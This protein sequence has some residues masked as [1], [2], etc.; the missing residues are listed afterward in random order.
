MKMKH[1]RAVL[2][3]VLYVLLAGSISAQTIP[4]S[5]VIPDGDYRAIKSRLL[6]EDSGWWSN[7]TEKEKGRRRSFHF[8]LPYIFLPS[9]VASGYGIPPSKNYKATLAFVRCT[10]SASMEDTLHITYDGVPFKP[11]DPL[12]NG[13]VNSYVAGQW[14]SHTIGINLSDMPFK[15]RLG[16]G[17]VVRNGEFNVEVQTN[18]L[19]QG[20]P[21][22]DKKSAY[23][24]MVLQLQ[25]GRVVYLMPGF[26]AERKY[27]EPLAE[28]MRQDGIVVD[29][30]LELA[31]VDK[32]FLQINSE[33]LVGILADDA[34]RKYGVELADVVVICHSAGAPV[35]AKVQSM[36]AGKQAGGGFGSIISVGGAFGGSD[37]API[38]EQFTEAVRSTLG[39]A[40]DFFIRSPFA[41]SDLRPENMRARMEEIRPFIPKEVTRST[42]EIKQAVYIA[43]TSDANVDDSEFG[44]IGTIN[45]EEVDGMFD[46]STTTKR[47]AAVAS[48]QTAYCLLGGCNGLFPNYNPSTKKFEG[49]L[50]QIFDAQDESSN[51]KEENDFVVRVS[52]QKYPGLY[53]PVVGPNLRALK[54]NHAKETVTTW[55]AVK[56]VM[57]TFGLN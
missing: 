22:P 11:N 54:G 57:A 42:G 37:W 49:G 20:K 50:F 30:S 47:A 38:A 13:V 15:L 43:V 7:Q 39:D 48:G 8:R 32:N 33:R 56:G 45:A 28:L 51:P 31:T 25:I 3:L 5:P 6:P 41:F 1:V 18:W 46:T 10:N 36:L 52:Q 40:S 17:G 21:E 27:M 14:V 16:D 12:E 34:W 29:N 2:G 4:T 53:F 24:Y 44:G 55:D 9:A 19:A 23:L 35:M 26:Q